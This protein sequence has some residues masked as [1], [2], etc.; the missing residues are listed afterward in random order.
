MPN[1]MSTYL[2]LLFIS[3]LEGCLPCTLLF[4]PNDGKSC[5]HTYRDLVYTFALCT[6]DVLITL[7]PIF[8]KN[9]YESNY[10]IFP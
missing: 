10:D 2:A 1:A 3:Q 5:I 9:D 7:S 6:S 8:Y 4:M